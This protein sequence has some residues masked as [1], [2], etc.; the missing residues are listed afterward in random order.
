MNMDRFM[1]VML[2]F[3]PDSMVGQD[4][5]G[6]I[7]IHTGLTLVSSATHPTV[8]EGETLLVPFPEV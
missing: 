5:D 6:Q 1:E 3:L 8:P 2:R 4:E 7:V